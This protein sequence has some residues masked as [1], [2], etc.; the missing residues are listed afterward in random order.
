MPCLVQMVR[1]EGAPPVLQLPVGRADCGHI[2]L[3]MCLFWRA[4]ALFQIA[5]QARG[6]DVFPAGASAQTARD[7]MVEGQIV[8]R[9][10]IL[11]FELVAQEQVEPR[12]CGIFGRLHILTQRNHRR[13]LHVDARAVHMPVIAGDDI[14]LIEE[15]RL[16]RGLPRPQA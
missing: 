2:E 13:D 12:K 4:T 11:A 5:G 7:D 10:A 6:G 1:R 8:R 3:H 9:P 15:N 16:D 14:D